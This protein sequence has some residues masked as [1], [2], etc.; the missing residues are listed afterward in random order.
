MTEG[1]IL[2]EALLAIAIGAISPSL[3][4]EQGH[5]RMYQ[6][7]IAVEVRFTDL[8]IRPWFG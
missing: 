6:P 3:A 1:P 7:R 2:Q 5:F 4:G 8:A